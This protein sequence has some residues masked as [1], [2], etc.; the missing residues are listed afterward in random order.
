[1]YWVFTGHFHRIVWC[2]FKMSLPASVNWSTGHGRTLGISS[3]A[4]SPSCP[5]IRL[6]TQYRLPKLCQLV[7]L[8]CAIK[9]PG[10]KARASFGRTMGL[11][12]FFRITSRG[13]GYQSRTT[14]DQYLLVTCLFHRSS[15]VRVWFY[16]RY[17]SPSIIL[18]SSIHSFLSSNQQALTWIST[19]SQ[20][21]PTNP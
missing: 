3:R 10:Q 20:A 9:S 14:L 8:Y 19:S 12:W 18:T 11:G 5:S 1:M 21:T 17:T 2:C 4:T 7:I 13:S 16:S 6:P 15:G